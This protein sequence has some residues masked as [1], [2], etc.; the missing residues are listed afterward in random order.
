MQL[1]IEREL[2]LQITYPLLISSLVRDLMSNP[3][4]S[5][6]SPESNCFLK[7]SIPVT[8]VLTDLALYPKIIYITIARLKNKLK[9]NNLITFTLMDTINN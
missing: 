4:L 5:P 2:G 1:W 3:I 8:V 7:V 9:L 6:A